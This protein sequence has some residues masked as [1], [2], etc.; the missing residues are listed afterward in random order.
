MA[1]K[2]AKR[3]K[4]L[5]PAYR[6]RLEAAYK[7]GTFGSGY[8]SAGRAYAAG[9][10]RQVARGQASTKPGKLSEAERTKRRKQ[11]SKAKAW[12]DKHSRVPATK[13]S[14]PK[15]LTADELADY[16]ARYVAFTK[17]VEKGWSNRKKGVKQAWDV[18][19]IKAW[20]PE[21]QVENPDYN[22]IS[23]LF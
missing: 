9:A 18:E 6:A 21:Y 23:P 7:S 17:E 1:R 5:T 8:S 19:K 13:Y 14:P 10:S 11:S 20:L 16:T 2:P 15:D 4:D 12:S 22:E 3:W